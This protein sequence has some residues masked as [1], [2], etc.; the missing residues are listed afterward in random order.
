MYAIIE[1]G[2]NQ[3]R[4]ETGLV[5]DVDLLH[6]EEG[7]VKFDRVLFISGGD[8][9]KVGSPYVKNGVVKGEILGEVKGEKG[10]F[11]SYK[12]RKNF[13]RKVGYRPRYS[14]VKITAIEPH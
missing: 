6:Q 7:E 10:V 2:G 9:P 14:R 4:V 5:I 11:F 3:Y 12:R 1:T 13:H 8:A